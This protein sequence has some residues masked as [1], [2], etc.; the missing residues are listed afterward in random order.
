MAIGCLGWRVSVGVKNRCLDPG[1]TEDA[2]GSVR[3]IRNVL[4]NNFPFGSSQVFMCELTCWSKHLFQ[5]VAKDGIMHSSRA[6]LINICYNTEMP[7]SPSLQVGLK[8]CSFFLAAMKVIVYCLACYSASCGM[9]L[10]EVS[11]QAHLF[12]APAAASKQ[13]SVLCRS[14]VSVVALCG[15]TLECWTKGG[16]KCRSQFLQGF[17]LLPAGS[18]ETNYD[19]W[20]RLFLI[21]MC[22]P[23]ALKQCSQVSDWSVVFFCFNACWVRW[24]IAPSDRAA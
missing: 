2:D 24:R 16:A 11:W 17:E 23:G 21:Q 12:V 1:S 8:F 5:S 13:A 4:T 15:G 19:K 18:T 7:C 20:S 10:W 3:F 9:A 22:F 6:T 14:W